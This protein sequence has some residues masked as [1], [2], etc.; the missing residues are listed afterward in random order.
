MASFGKW[1][2]QYRYEPGQKYSP[3]LL[4]KGLDV[5]LALN[6][7]GQKLLLEAITECVMSDNRLSIAEAELIRAICASLNCPLPP[8]LVEEPVT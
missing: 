7:D 2:D 8:I 4:D 5:L 1:A 3:A 6:S